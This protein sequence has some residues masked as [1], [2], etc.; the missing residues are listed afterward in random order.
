MGNGLNSLSRVLQTELAF[1]N[2]NVHCTLCILGAINTGIHQRIKN[3]DG[4]Q[5]SEGWAKWGSIDAGISASECAKLICTATCNKLKE[6][7]ICQQPELSLM[8]ATQQFP[9]LYAAFPKIWMN[10]WSF[11][12]FIELVN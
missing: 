11:P 4:S 1:L 9:N 5:G 7:W 10:K 3:A 2:E 6:V 8:Y 12:P